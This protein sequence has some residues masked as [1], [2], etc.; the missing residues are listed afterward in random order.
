[1]LLTGYVSTGF[2]E[3]VKTGKAQVAG[4]GFG[5]KGLDR[6][7]KE[8]E[9]K[10]RA[11]RKAYGEPE[12]EKAEETQKASTGATGGDDMTF[13]NF[14]VEIRRG[15]APDSSKGMLGVPGA[16]AA[17]RRLA[18]A[19]EEEKIQAQ[20][21]TAQDAANRA[22]KD[23][24]AQK[25]ALSVVAKLNAQLKAM[26]LVLQS[27]IQH[28]ESGGRKVNPDST[29][30]HAIIPINDYP[31]KARWRVTNKETMVQ[32]RV[33]RHSHESLLTIFTIAHRY[34]W[35]VGHQQG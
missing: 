27:Q 25:Q 35:G 21:K 10:D 8:R 24:P 28:E 3:K 18:H 32:V 2:L 30:F 31:Q 29:D 17:A 20:I 7:D 4:S 9:A 1:M 12:E 13:G 11:E 23:S 5:G 15:P 22:G 34:D 16:A 33:S 14:K 26:K 6:L 19:K